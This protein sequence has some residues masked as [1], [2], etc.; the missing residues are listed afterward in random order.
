MPV[1]SVESRLRL[2]C[3]THPITVPLH[4][5]DVRKTQGGGE[6][7]DYELPNARRIAD[8]GLLWARA[9]LSKARLSY[10]RVSE[11]FDFSSVTFWCSVL[12]ILFAIQFKAVVVSN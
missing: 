4:A 1:S 11:N 10:R 6:S 12:F 8:D 3:I 2:N 5:R 9:G 7:G